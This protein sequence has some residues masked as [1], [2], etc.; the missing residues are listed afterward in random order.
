MSEEIRKKRRDLQERM[1]LGYIVVLMGN[2]MKSSQP[3]LL[4]GHL[5]KKMT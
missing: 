1:R 5:T 4:K 2:G 3:Y